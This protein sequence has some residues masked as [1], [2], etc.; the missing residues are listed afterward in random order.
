MEE[1]SF[2]KLVAS[3]RSWQSSGWRVR[4][5]ELVKTRVS[6]QSRHW[7]VILRSCHVGGK[8][9]VAALKKRKAHESIMNV[10]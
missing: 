1:V 9:L 5:Q 6:G 3:G 10:G 4:K 2:S 7:C 8:A